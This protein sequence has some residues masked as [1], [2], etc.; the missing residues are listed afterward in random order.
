MHQRTASRNTRI[1]VCSAGAAALA[2][3][4]CTFGVPAKTA[5]TAG[6][7]VML[8]V[9]P[10]GTFKPNDGRELKPGAW[11]I[12]AASAESVIARFKARGKPPVIDYEHQTLKKETNGQPAPAA[13]WM[14]E[15]RWVEGQGLYALA[16]LTARAREYIGAG[17]YLYFSP[18]FE[19]D[20]ATGEVLAIHM[21]ALTNDPGI[22]GMEPLSLVAAATAAFLPTNLP[23]QET[24]V[25]PLLKALL[26]AFGLPDTTTE[27]QATAAL[28]AL[29]PLKPLQERAAV[30]TAACTALQ[31]PA[32]ATPEAVTAACTTLRT[33]QPGTPDPAKFVPIESVTALQGQI[34]TLTARQLEADVEAQIKPALADGRLLPALEGWARGLGKS[35]IAALTAYLGAA[36][37]IAAL[38]GTQ[39]NGKPPANTA[40]GDQQLSAD[41]LAVCSAMGLTPEAYRK[42]GTAVATGAAA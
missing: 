39:T 22:S 13:G 38:A 14:R 20:P 42:A 37:P 15:L 4:A 28:T 18:V 5:Q 17:E 25:N 10:A 3:A 9:T 40:S 8:Q 31:L 23:P 12:D 32:D 19:Y 16:E 27:Q 7:T 2:I 30:A 11:R 35:D 41:E 21:G 26:A 33:A 29:G 1:A 6:G 34:A 36:K 24:S